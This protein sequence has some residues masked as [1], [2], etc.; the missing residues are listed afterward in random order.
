MSDTSQIAQRLDD[1]H[2]QIETARARAG[3]PEVTLVAVSKTHP[4]EAVEA[5]LAAGQCDFG[6]NRVQEMLAKAP[7]VSSGARWHL[8]GHLQSN[9]IR[10]ALAVSEIFHGI[11]SLALAHDVDRIAQEEGCRPK[12]FLET[13]VSGEGSKYGFRP[14]TLIS[15]WEE[16]LALGR[17]EPVGLM[18]IPPIGKAEESRP[19]FVKLRQLRDRLEQQGGVPLPYLS[20]GMSGDFAVA[21]EEGA[22]HVRIGTAI[23]GER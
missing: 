15:E 13:N 19:F 4:P 21:I 5:A 8:V 17:V 12:I 11:D 1:I 9:K 20:M 18:T 22:T 16:I 2:A 14:E 6:E 10:K 23:F 3:T 7:L